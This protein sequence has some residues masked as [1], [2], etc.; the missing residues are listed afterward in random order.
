[1]SVCKSCGATIRWAVTA[2]NG[3]RIPLDPE[4]S[5]DGNLVEV[6]SDSPGPVVAKVAADAVAYPR[7][8]SHFATCAFAAHHRKR[9]AGG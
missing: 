5:L 3:R 8:T 9:K 7:Y 4:P 2:K 6:A 1:M